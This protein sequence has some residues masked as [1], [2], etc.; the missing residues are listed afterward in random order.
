MANF[1]TVPDGMETY[2]LPD[3]LYAVFLHKIAAV[4]GATAFQYIY[5]TWAP[6]SDYIFDK[7][8]QFEILGEKYKYKYNDPT[9]E[10]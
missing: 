8:A 9:S 10:E 3:V 2:T 6:N 4:I 1:D 5:G 7:R